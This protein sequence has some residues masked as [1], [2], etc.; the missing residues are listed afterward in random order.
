MYIQKFKFTLQNG[1]IFVNYNNYIY[2]HFSF[3]NGVF[4]KG[5]DDCDLLDKAILLI[6]YKYN[7]DIPITP[8]LCFL[9]GVPALNV[10]ILEPVNLA[11][12]DFVQKEGAVNIDAKFNNVLAHGFSSHTINDVR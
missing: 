9:S 2:V 8:T 5:L 11:S 4:K 10:P 1:I 6:P 7:S 12:F 3:C